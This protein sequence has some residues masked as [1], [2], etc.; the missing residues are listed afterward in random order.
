MNDKERPI[1]QRKE[2]E[3]G[4]KEE[5]LILEGDQGKWEGV[6]SLAMHMAVSLGFGMSQMFS[7]PKIGKCTK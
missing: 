6:G 4:H 3:I 7:F 1:F 2:I 5:F